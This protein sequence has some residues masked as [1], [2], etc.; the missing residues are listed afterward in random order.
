[1]TFTVYFYGHPYSIWNGW[2]V[3]LI[4]K[5]YQKVLWLFFWGLCYRLGPISSLRLTLCSTFANPPAYLL[6]PY[7]FWSIISSSFVIQRSFLAC[8]IVE[9]DYFQLLVGCCS[10]SDQYNDRTCISVN[11]DLRQ[12]LGALSQLSC[13]RRYLLCSRTCLCRSRGRVRALICPS[14]SPRCCQTTVSARLEYHSDSWASTTTTN[15]HSTC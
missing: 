10:Q 7:L 13:R 6:L 8:F 2:F 15:P 12:S 3:H 14:H 4:F 5:L 11:W 9:L 1:M